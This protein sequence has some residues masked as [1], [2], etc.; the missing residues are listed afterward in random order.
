VGRG[1]VVLEFAVEARRVRRV[2]STEY[3][4]L[5]T[6]HQDLDVSGCAGS[7]EQRQP[8]ITRVSSR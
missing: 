3:G 2:V 5:V 6:E 8:L 7:G 4:D 1:V